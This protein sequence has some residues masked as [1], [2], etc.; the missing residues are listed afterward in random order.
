M[1]NQVAII[2][3]GPS[4]CALA[5]FLQQRGIDCLVFDNNKTPELLV[6]E[7]LVPA[8]IPILRRLGIEDRVAAISHIKRGAALRHGNGVRVDFEFQPFGRIY[9]DYSYNIPRPQFDRVLRERAEELGV[10]FIPHRANVEAVD[11][12]PQRD[13]RLSS[14]SLLAAGLSISKQPDLLVDATGRSRLFSRKLKISA[15]RG[16][17]TDIAHFAHYRDFAADSVLD[18]QVVL[19]ALECGWSW[20]IPLPGLTSVGVVM[21]ADSARKYGDTAEERLENAIEHNEILKRAGQRRERIS[22]V[23]TYSNYQ[24]ISQ[25]AHGRG[26]VLLGDA[27]GFVDPMLSPGVFMALESA[28]ILDKLL[29]DGQQADREHIDRQ[30][31]EYYTQMLHWHES[32][33][34]LIKYFYDG[35]ILSMGEMRDFIRH[36]SS[37]FSISRLAEPVVSRILSQLVSGVATRSEFKHAALHHT[38]RHLIRDKAQAEQNRIAGNL[39]KTQL[40]ALEAIRLAAEDVAQAGGSAA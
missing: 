13:L 2:G 18:G 3:A 11:N 36:R 22:C 8:V 33:S 15:D 25:R 9:P 34:R 16:P 20:Q 23:Q 7:S 38:C 29:F 32:W 12:D 6:G 10:R 5:C 14:D 40:E 28:V 17:R 30:C 27:L 31:A 37:W 39:S 4:G 1:I 35:R 26:W 21:N 19:S 24:L